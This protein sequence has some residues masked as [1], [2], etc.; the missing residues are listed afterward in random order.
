MAGGYEILYL[1]CRLKHVLQQIPESSEDFM[2][3]LSKKKRLQFEDL[4]QDY[5]VVRQQSGH[6]HLTTKQV[7]ERLKQQAEENRR[8]PGNW[9]GEVEEEELRQEL[10]NRQAFQPAPRRRAGPYDDSDDEDNNRGYNYDTDREDDFSDEYDMRP[11]SAFLGEGQ[12]PGMAPNRS[13]SQ[14]LPR[15]APRSRV[16]FALPT[17]NAQ[18]QPT[19]QQALT[20]RQRLPLNLLPSILREQSR[21]A[22]L[23]QREA[24]RMSAQFLEQ[25]RARLSPPSTSTAQQTPQPEQSARAST[26]N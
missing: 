13:R 23:S 18:Q 6:Y 2:R 14:G 11:E 5:S 22:G 3:R 1:W 17:S 10:R 4:D 19:G 20:S 7:S 26:H 8:N 15:P 25:W 9:V 21:R 12:R 16:A 24:A